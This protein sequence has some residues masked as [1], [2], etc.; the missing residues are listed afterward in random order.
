[1]ILDD[2]REPI[3][4]VDLV[5]RI[6]PTTMIFATF[7]EKDGSVF[8]LNEIETR[9]DV[10]RMS[11]QYIMRLSIENGATDPYSAFIPC[12]NVICSDEV[13]STR[14]KTQIESVNSEENNNE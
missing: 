7:N 6:D 11:R 1:M 10:N 5:S 14:I 2:F 13:R 12:L 3:R 4:F 9:E 8:T